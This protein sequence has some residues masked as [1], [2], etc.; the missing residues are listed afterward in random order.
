MLFLKYDQI[1]TNTIG[2][3][4]LYT[5]YYPNS[6]PFPYKFFFVKNIFSKFFFNLFIIF[7]LISFSQDKFITVIFYY[8]FTICIAWSIKTSFFNKKKNFKL[9][10][11]FLLS[12]TN[13]FK[14]FK[15]AKNGKNTVV[16][17]YFSNG[18]I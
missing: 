2:C 6:Y 16:L 9:P 17:L 18:R 13:P 7:Y 5:V 4:Y 12:S 15:R 11:L 10:C 14:S 1:R 8:P 3:A